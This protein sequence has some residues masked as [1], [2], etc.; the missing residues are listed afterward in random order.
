MTLTEIN[1]RLAFA[2]YPTKTVHR[3]G[4]VVR[5]NGRVF[6]YRAPHTMEH[7]M[8][9]LKHLAININIV[10][11]HTTVNGVRGDTLSHA[12]ALAFLNLEKS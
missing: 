9:R 8:H 4:E 3:N 7:L 6:D 1:T 2:L 10:E 12:V 5:C 11:G